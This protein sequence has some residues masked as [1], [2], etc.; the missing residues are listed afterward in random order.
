[1][2]T[3]Q[4]CRKDKTDTRWKES[5]LT[6]NKTQ[7]DQE[8]DFKN[9]GFHSLSGTTVLTKYERDT[10]FKTLCSEHIIGRIHGHISSP[11]T[12]LFN[13]YFTELTLAYISWCLSLPDDVLIDVLMQFEMTDN[14]YTNQS[15]PVSGELSQ[16]KKYFCIFLSFLKL[17]LPSRW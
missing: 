7:Q 10:A 11:H 8:N 14:N 3:W 13:F 1:M 17:S 5:N 12:T 4:L 15:A 16:T 6:T 2:I 9:S